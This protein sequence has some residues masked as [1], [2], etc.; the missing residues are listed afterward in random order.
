LLII[1]KNLCHPLS[2]RTY[3]QI[4]DAQILPGVDILA[5]GNEPFPRTFMREYLQKQVDV[6]TEETIY[7]GN[8]GHIGVF[9]T[10]RGQGLYQ[11]V[12]RNE[13]NAFVNHLMPLG[14]ISI[15]FKK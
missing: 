11:L 10:E 8:T 7:R 3:W 1:I 12:S 13:W 9:V 2:Q 14:V 6:H 4:V 5:L 15:G